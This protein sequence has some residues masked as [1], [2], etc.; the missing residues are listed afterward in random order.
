MFVK[1]S[2]QLHRHYYS[3]VTYFIDLAKPT[4]NKYIASNAIG[5]LRLQWTNKTH[6][7]KQI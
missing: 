2:N 7:K 1:G 6:L 4:F 5:A 3:S